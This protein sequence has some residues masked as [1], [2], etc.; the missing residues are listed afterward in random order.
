MLIKSLNPDGTL[1]KY[2]Y[3]RLKRLYHLKEKEYFTVL[4]L[5]KEFSKLLNKSKLGLRVE[6]VNDQEYDRLNTEL[7]ELQLKLNISE[8]DTHLLND[9]K[10]LSYGL[11]NLSIGLRLI[12]ENRAWYKKAPGAYEPFVDARDEMPE[13]IERIYM[14]MSTWVKLQLKRSMLKG[15]V[16]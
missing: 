16:L 10:S 13:T 1:N 15:G 14:R 12:N 3:K 11:Y 5:F 9:L 2:G 6:L 4:P 7:I 8:K